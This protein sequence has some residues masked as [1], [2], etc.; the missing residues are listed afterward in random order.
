MLFLIYLIKC[1]SLQAGSETYIPL[2]MDN[3][4]TNLV[5][6]L[7]GAIAGSW[8]TY[9][10][11]LRIES[12][13]AATQ[14]KAERD[15]LSLLLKLEF[16]TLQTCLGRMKDVVDGGGIFLFRWLN[17]AKKNISFI[18]GI[19]EKFY[20][21]ADLELQ[22]RLFTLTSDLSTLLSD[23]ESIES[24]QNGLN[25]TPAK[26]PTG[27][28]ASLEEKSNQEEYLKEQRRLKLV[29]LVDTRRRISEIIKELGK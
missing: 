22:V 2:Y 12:V 7:L 27:S 15:N 9:L 3:V 28:S 26:S 5:A 24:W 25:A 13:K 19:R 17:P 29:D 6:V 11:N 1:S 20:L 23:I 4:I 14:S 21:L 10:A 18:E 8:G 16:E